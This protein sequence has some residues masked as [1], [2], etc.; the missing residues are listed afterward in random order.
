MK[1][2][3]LLR[4]INVGGN[5]KVTM[6]ILKEKLT[7]AGLKNV[8]T[9]INSGNLIFDSKLKEK[10]LAELVEKMIK[11]TFDVISKTLIISKDN[12]EMIA[13]KIPVHYKN[14]GEFKSDVMFYYEGVTKDM[15][16]AL[17]FKKEFEEVIYLDNA[18]IY[19]IPK[20]FVTR[21]TLTKIIG[22]KLY[23]VVTVRNVNTT[24]KLVELLN[25]DV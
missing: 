12:Y 23:H 25:Q 2:V 22:T 3:C 14:D 1:Y 17:K 11:D 24:R 5:N 4:G 8:I 20:K 10:E 16:D 19:G 6:S 18:L 15:I 21:S 7:D 9:Y 13:S